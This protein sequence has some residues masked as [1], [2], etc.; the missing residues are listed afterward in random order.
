MRIRNTGAGWT[1]IAFSY[2]GL[3][4]NP[5]TYTME[6]EK[7]PDGKYSCIN[8]AN[9]RSAPTAKIVKYF[10][11]PNGAVKSI[12]KSF[13]GNKRYDIFTWQF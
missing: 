6:A 4:M 7:D 12:I 10:L 5:D 2:N 3:D 11:T 13:S 9:S 8:K 1:F